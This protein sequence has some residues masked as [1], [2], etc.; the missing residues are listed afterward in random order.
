MRIRFLGVVLLSMLAVSS[1][2]EPQVKKANCDRAC[3]QG[4]MDRYLKAMLDR[5][6]SDDLFARN[7]RFTENGI[8]LPLGNEGLWY[9]MSGLGG[10]RFY[11]PDIETQQIAMIGSVKE[12][13]GNHGVNDDQGN[14]VAVAIRLKIADGKISEVEQLAIRPTVQLGGRGGGGARGGGAPAGGGRGAAPGG[15]PAGAAAG[16]R[17]AAPGGAGA[18]GRGGGAAA[19]GDNPS[20]GDR[21]AA[22]KE[23]NPIFLQAI[24]ENERAS[25]EELVTQA[26]Y[27]FT[28]L[29]R[30]D[31]NG[32]YP[33]TEGCVRFENG[34][35]AT[36]DCLAQFTGHSLDNI[37][38]RIRDRRF[39]AVD[40]ERG[41]VFSFAFFDHY[42]I[43][44][45]WQLAEL[46]KIEKGKIRRIEAV[47]HQA[48]FGIPSG[49]S[50]YEQS[51]SE[52]IQSIR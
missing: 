2:A 40:R 37:V 15:A 48:P 26:N 27:Y 21:V 32:Y 12:N 39:V 42:R 49:W 45:T 18:G 25:R 33:F 5:N 22:M 28:A 24:P 13:M 4:Y 6:V 52:E 36:S 1:F 16:G 8:Q 29:A 30:H 46:F 35:T 11:V 43:N 9:G 17:G 38:D 44:W 19:G 3:L 31:G 14:N 23:P 20:T 50:T 47:F 34:M 7:V 10:Y 41:I 51:I